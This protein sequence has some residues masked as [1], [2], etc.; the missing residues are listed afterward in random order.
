MTLL[1]LLRQASR[2]YPALAWYDLLIAGL[3]EL[4]AQNNKCVCKNSHGLVLKDDGW[5]CTRCGWSRRVT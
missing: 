1:R 2:L 4:I 5:Y 3:E